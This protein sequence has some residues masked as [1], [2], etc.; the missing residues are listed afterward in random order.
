M[1][2]QT[3]DNINEALD[4]IETKLNGMNEKLDMIVNEINKHKNESSETVTTTYGTKIMFEYK[5]NDNEK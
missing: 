5:Q 3:M 4:R 1:A 2:Q